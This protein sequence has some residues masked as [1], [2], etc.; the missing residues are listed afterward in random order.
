MDAD[1]LPPAWEK[2]VNKL[3]DSYNLGVPASWMA[4]HRLSAPKELERLVAEGDLE[5]VARE[6]LTAKIDGANEEDSDVDE[7]EHPIHAGAAQH[8]APL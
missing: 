2:K 8:C 1:T 3:I 6:Q 5:L 7:E 4:V